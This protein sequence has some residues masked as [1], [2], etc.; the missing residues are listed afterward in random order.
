MSAALARAPL[1]PPPNAPLPASP[2]PV[3]AAAWSSSRAVAVPVV[4]FGMYA[5]FG[6]SWM[7]VVPLF[8]EVKTALGV[9][10]ADAA[11]L[12]TIVSLV[13][14]VVPILAGIFAARVGLTTSLRVAAVLIATSVLTP[15]LPSWGAQVAAR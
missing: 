15:W 8:P 2:G 6:A 9:D 1:P 11:W 10:A 3:A 12:V 14:S 13:K 7:S 5:A 4:L